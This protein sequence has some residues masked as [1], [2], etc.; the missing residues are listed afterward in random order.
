MQTTMDMLETALRLHPVPH[1]TKKL[2][3]SRSGTNTGFSGR[4]IQP[5]WF[6]T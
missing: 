3:L 1:W 4:V 5:H 2:N 6:A